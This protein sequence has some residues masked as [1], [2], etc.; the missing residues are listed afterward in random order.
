MDRFY[1]VGAVD[2]FMRN[3]RTADQIAAQP[4][5]GN[6]LDIWCAFQRR[7]LS[8]PCLRPALRR[9]A[10]ASASTAVLAHCWAETPFALLGKQNVR[11]GQSWHVCA[12]RSVACLFA[13]GRAY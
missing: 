2:S 10:L 13:V 5:S 7:T 11:T 4:Y 9:A 6:M 8:Q 3:N 1:D 12:S